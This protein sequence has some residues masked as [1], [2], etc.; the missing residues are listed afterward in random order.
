MQKRGCERD[1]QPPTP[2]K[3]DGEER[4]R[5]AKQYTRSCSQVFRAV[6]EGDEEADQM[7]SEV[8]VEEDSREEEM[9][10][11][12]E[13]LSKGGE[14]EEEDF[15]PAAV[16]AQE[17]RAKKK[18]NELKRIGN[19][20]VAATVRNQAVDQGAAKEGAVL[21]VPEIGKNVQSVRKSR[22]T[23]KQSHAVRVTV[24]NAPAEPGQWGVL[25]SMA[26]CAGGEQGSVQGQVTRDCFMQS[27]C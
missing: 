20:S 8:F 18:I 13:A 16:C 24:G 11:S 7:P 22:K 12:F 6:L 14:D 5:R 25:S 10:S 19:F 15:M 1:A 2:Y 4:R 17:Y 3:R 21:F 9:T 23:A 27:N 26:A